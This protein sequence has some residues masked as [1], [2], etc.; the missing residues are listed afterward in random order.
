VP[1]VDSE[2]Q[3]I[4][5][6]SCGR[7]DH[8][9][10]CGYHLTPKEYFREHP[11]NIP[12]ST[13]TPQPR[14]QPD[15]INFGSVEIWDGRS[16]NERYNSDFAQALHLF[17]DTEVVHRLVDLYRLQTTDNGYMNVMFPNIDINNVV[18]SVMV[19]GYNKDLHRNDI[20]YRYKGNERW[21]RRMEEEH[22]NGVVYGS[23]FF[24]EHL[25]NKRPSASVAIVESQK[26]A[27]ICAAIHPDKIWLASCGCQQFKPQLFKVL[28]GRSVTVYP[29]KGSENKWQEVVK[30]LSKELDVTVDPIMQSYPTYGENSDIADVIL[31]RLKRRVLPLTYET[32]AKDYLQRKPSVSDLFKSFDLVIKSLTYKNLQ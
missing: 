22:P 11:E 7:C 12:T 23:C 10:S 32:I 17:F 24:G 6:E 18:Q 21:K 25:L 19:V 5:S 13:F 20:C 26:S 3:E 4:I 16:G 14:R 28:Q 8:E 31:D 30:S 15:T 2:T 27:V 1:Y 29:D 9:S